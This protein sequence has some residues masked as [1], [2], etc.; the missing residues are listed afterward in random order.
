MKINKLIDHTILKPAASKQD[1]IKLCEEAVKYDFMSVC[2]NP[3]WVKFAAEKLKGT[4]VKVCTVIGFPLGAN[5]TEVKVFEA[6]NALAN[7]AQELDMVI[8][9]GAL[10]SGM[11]EDVYHD[12]KLIRDLGKY[13]LKVIF[14]TALLSKEEIVKV[15][16]LCVCAGADFVKTST[17]FADGGATVE[18]VRLMK[19]NIAAAM[20]V[21]A[22]G[23]VRDLEALQKMVEAGAARIGT[24]SGVKIMESL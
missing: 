21:K 6:K 4:D 12:I 5:T 8:N 1:I 10:K 3:F 13:T 18:D 15:C 16:E 22:S 11:F 17:G 23:G 7:G 19:A 14:E 24:S 20:R 9:V 2:V